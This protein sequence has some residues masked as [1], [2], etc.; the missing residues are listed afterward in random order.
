MF[1]LPEPTTVDDPKC[2]GTT[3]GWLVLIVGL[4]VVVFLGYNV[5]VWGLP[6]VLVALESTRVS[7]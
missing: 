3:G 6:L 4:A 1:G 2:V 5:K 7:S